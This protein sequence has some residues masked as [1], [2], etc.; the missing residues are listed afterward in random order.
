MAIGSLLIAIHRYHRSGKATAILSM[1][2]S[3]TT[4]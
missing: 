2:Q 4:M 3:T 1:L